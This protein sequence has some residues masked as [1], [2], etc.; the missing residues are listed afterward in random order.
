MMTRQDVLLPPLEQLESA[1]AARAPGRERD[2]A[3]QVD[4]VLGGV[5]EALRRHVA[6]AEAPN[7]GMFAE[8]D[9]TRPTLVRQVGTLRQEHTSFLERAKALRQELRSAAKVFDPH[10]PAGEPGTLP[11]AAEPEAVPDFGSLRKQLEDFAAAL[12]RHRA[13]EAGLVLE[14]VTTDLGAGD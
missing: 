12:K 4:A 1:L 5:Q 3:G 10:P 6:D 11:R 7:A 2:W 14:S 13:D 9:L 8:V